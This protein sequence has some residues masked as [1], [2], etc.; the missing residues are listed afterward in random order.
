MLIHV[1]AQ[2]K[3]ETYPVI[4]PYAGEHEK[5]RLVTRGNKARYMDSNLWKVV[6]AEASQ[7][8]LDA[9]SDDSDD[10]AM[11]RTHPVDQ[12]SQTFH[13]GG[14]LLGIADTNELPIEHPDAATILRLWQIYLDY[15]NPITKLIHAPTLQQEI[16]AAISNMKNITKS[17]EALMCGCY[18]LAIMSLD[19]EQA[20]STFGESKEVLFFRYS[21]LTRRALLNSN[22]LRTSDITVLIAFVLYI[23]SLSSGGDFESR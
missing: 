10:D 17:L 19:P 16:I 20:Q 11:D 8:A 21:S 5:G 13:S 6:S 23:I 15:V 3:R 4:N 22:F 12:P 7:A 9:S 14:L 1:K 18:T 2:E